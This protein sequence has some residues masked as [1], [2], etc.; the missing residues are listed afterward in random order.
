MTAWR[1]KTE[2]FSIRVFRLRFCFTVSPCQQPF[3]IG[4]IT[5]KVALKLKFD[6]TEFKSSDQPLVLGSL[7]TSFKFRRFE[8][9]YFEI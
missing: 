9:F 7:S 1:Y 3:K 6:L 4:K 8:N 2:L 5:L